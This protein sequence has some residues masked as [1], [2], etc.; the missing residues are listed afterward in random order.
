MKSIVRAA[1]LAAFLAATATA[2]ATG[3][4][5]GEAGSYPERAIR[6]V[7]PYAAGGSSG[8]TARV[9]AEQIQK[10]WGQAVIVDDRPGGNTIIGSNIVARAAADGYTLLWQNDAHVTSQYLFHTPYDALKDFQPVATVAST[11]NLLV[12]NPEVPANS[13]KELIDYAKKHPSVLN[14]GSTGLGGPPHLAAELF[15]SLTGTQI[16]HIPYPGISPALTALVGGQVQMVIQSPSQALQY[17][18]TGRLKA[19][20]VTGPRRLAALPDV[21]TFAEAG[22]PDFQIRQWFGLFMPANTPRP[23][24]DKWNDE[25]RKLLA[26]PEVKAKLGAAGLDPLVSSPEEFSSIIKADSAR[27]GKLIKSL[28]IKAE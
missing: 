21:P 15:K 17:V 10:A 22:L 16:T 8:T 12:V 5:A 7:S 9:I 3:A 11:E 14:Y 20:A 27:Y 28:G 18:K 6:I 23:I 2:T 19:L 25:M 4:A 13:V 26:L 1:I 24:V